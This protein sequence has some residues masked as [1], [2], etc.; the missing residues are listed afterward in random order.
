MLDCGPGQLAAGGS[1]DAAA[2]GGSEETVAG[3]LADETAAGNSAAGDTPPALDAEAIREL[4]RELYWFQ[5]A[6]RAW[7]NRLI[8]MRAQQ[9]G[10][11]WL[12]P[13]QLQEW[14]LTRV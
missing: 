9:V 6:A 11:S 4:A 13:V 14:V 2:V 5:G 8:P 12:P 10:S 7:R 1:S 3:G